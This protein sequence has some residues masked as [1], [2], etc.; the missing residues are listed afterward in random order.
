MSRS[1][2]RFPLFF[3]GSVSMN[4]GELGL[5]RDLKTIRAM[6][7]EWMKWG[8]IRIGRRGRMFLMDIN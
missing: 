6:E 5:L 4:R 1:T 3:S 7:M 2:K 8:L